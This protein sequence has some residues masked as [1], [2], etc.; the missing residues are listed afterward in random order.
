MLHDELPP[1]YLAEALSD[2]M[3]NTASIPARSKGNNDFDRL[4]WP[5]LALRRLEKAQSG[6]DGQ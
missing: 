2:D 3:R 6:E 4:L 5:A 1:K